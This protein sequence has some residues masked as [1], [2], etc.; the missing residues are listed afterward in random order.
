M[1]ALLQV[2]VDDRTMCPICKYDPALRPAERHKH[3]SEQ[4]LRDHWRQVHSPDGLYF[5]KLGE[6]VQGKGRWLH[7]RYC[8]F[9]ITGPCACGC[10][11]RIS[12]PT[13]KHQWLPDTSPPYFL[14]GHRS[15]ILTEHK[16]RFIKG[17][18][19]ANKGTKYHLP[20]N[21][22]MY[23]KG[24]RPANYNGGISHLSGY[25]YLRTNERHAC[26]AIKYVSQSRTIASGILG[27]PLNSNEVVIH[28]DG[29]KTNDDLPNL[30]VVTRAES[31]SIHRDCSAAGKGITMRH[32]P[33]IKKLIR[34]TTKLIPRKIKK[35]KTQKTVQKPKKIKVPKVPV[36]SKPELPAISPAEI[37]KPKIEISNC[38][39]DPPSI[40]CQKCKSLRL[41]PAGP[42]PRCEKSQYLDWVTEARTRSQVAIKTGGQA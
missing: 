38:R 5:L 27:R 32:M 10:D 2:F 19:P 30:R 17:H 28:L 9:T 7:N 18:V 29:D 34:K 22:T 40:F 26:G 42:C 36:K 37:K 4:C 1:R 35:I 20:R 25:I 21:P 12:Y 3:Y 16:G 31:A 15:R 24:H 13:P 39:R 6:V 23:E 33:L 14:S 8:S 11:K 41:N